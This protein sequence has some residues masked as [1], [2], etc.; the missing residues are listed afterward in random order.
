L[1]RKY[2]KK[3]KKKAPFS[4]KGAKKKEAYDDRRGGVVLC[5][6]VVRSMGF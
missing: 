3:D 5:L 1:Q 2:S 4:E 6:E